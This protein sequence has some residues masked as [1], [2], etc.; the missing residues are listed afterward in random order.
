MPVTIFYDRRA[1]STTEQ[2]FFYESRMTRPNKEL[3]TN[4]PLDGQFDVEVRIK[5]VVIVPEPQVVS[6]TT[7]RDTG[8]LDDLAAFLKTATVLIQVARGPITYLPLA[9]ALSSI[10]VSGMAH[11]SQATAADGTL[12]AGSISGPLEGAGLDVDIVVP[13]RTDFNFTIK[14]LSAINIGDLQVYLIAE[15]P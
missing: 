4:M 14:Q 9:P 1:V 2:R 12:L 11:Y 13:V 5:K 10:K 6:S 3:D 7:Q 15:V 8:R